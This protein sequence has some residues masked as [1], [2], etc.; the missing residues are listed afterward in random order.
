MVRRNIETM[1][2]AVYQGNRQIRLEQLPLPK[3][4]PGELL[5]KV[6]GCGLCATDVSKVDHALVTPP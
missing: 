1:N 4:G 5:V 6:S 2:A 3:I